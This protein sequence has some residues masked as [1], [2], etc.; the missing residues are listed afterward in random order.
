MF[1]VNTLIKQ[2]KKEKHV[3][4]IELMSYENN[5]YLYVVSTPKE[6]FPRT[7]DVRD[8]EQLFISYQKPHGPVPKNTLARWIRDSRSTAGV[9]TTLFTAHGTPSAS[10]YPGHTITYH[11]SCPVV[12]RVH[13]RPILQKGTYCQHGPGFAGLFCREELMKVQGLFFLLLLLLL[14]FM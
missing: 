11:E 5:P 12:S 14:L 10:T 8:T 2:S 13:F 4:P 7:K 9:N 1:W 6:Y 3:A